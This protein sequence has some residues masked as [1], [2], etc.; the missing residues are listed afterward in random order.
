MCAFERS[1]KGMEF[2]MKKIGMLIPCTN[3]TVEYELEYL[4]NK[5]YF[6]TEKYAFYIFYPA[7]ILILAII[8]KITMG[9]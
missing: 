4:Y 9:I 1:E 8:R 7:H 3:L 2:N 6:N 5:Q